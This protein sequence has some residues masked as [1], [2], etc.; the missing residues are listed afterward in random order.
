MYYCDL[1]SITV[2]NFPNYLSFFFILFIEVFLNKD[3]KKALLFSF[4]NRWVGFVQQWYIVHKR[5]EGSER[6]SRCKISLKMYASDYCR[7]K[8]N[9]SDD[10]LYSRCTSI[11]GWSEIVTFSDVRKRILC[12]RNIIWVQFTQKS[13]NLA[14]R[15]L[16]GKVFKFIKSHGP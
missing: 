13:A 8:H 4:N 3:K 5:N 7:C 1:V 16:R 14:K 11:I 9:I 12:C 10:Q 2:Y 6:A 15:C